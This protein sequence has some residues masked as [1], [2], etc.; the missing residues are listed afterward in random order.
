MGPTWGPPGS[1][2]QCLKLSQKSCRSS[3]LE[4]QIINLKL[5]K[6]QQK[7]PSPPPKLSASDR[8]TC[9]NFQHCLSAPDGPHVG[10]MS[11]AIRDCIWNRP[12]Y[13]IQH[14][15][16]KVRTY[17]THYIH[18]TTTTHIFAWVCEHHYCD[19]T[20]ASNHQQVDCCCNSLLRLA[21]TKILKLHIIGPLWEESTNHW[22]IPLTKGQW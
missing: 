7:V 15:T 8:R 11:F 20:W 18:M 12:W 4:S 16:N 14:S 19:I 10:L 2:Q 21:T 9:G 3:C 1:C 6:N 17:T 5:K 22:W 13:C